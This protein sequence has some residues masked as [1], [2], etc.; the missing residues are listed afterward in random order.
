MMRQCGTILLA[1]AA[2]VAVAPNARADYAVLRS[3]LRIHITGYENTGDRV[4][5]TVEGGA[6]EIAAS[7]VV[8]I[9]PEDTFP[10]LPAE[11]QAPEGL[12]GPLIRAAAKKNGVDEKLI[13]R[14]IAAESN[15]N[16]KAVS[17]KRAL[18][19]M[20][21]LPETAARYSVAN[22]FDPAQNIEGGTH[23]LKDLLVRYG[24]NLALVLAAYNAGPDTVE[25]YGG[26]PPFAETQN[27]VKRVTSKLAQASSLLVK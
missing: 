26:V 12:Y 21:L 15:F 25:R 6:V 3:G 8:S 4:R 20:Q 24:G 2:T 14:V 16:P 19:L 17:S 7:D 13:T 1:L 23:Y 22:P 11:Q 27:Y 5:L 9:E 10:P 18:G